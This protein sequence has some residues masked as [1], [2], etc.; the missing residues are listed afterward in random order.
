[1]LLATDKTVLT[2]HAG[3]MAQWPVYLTICNLSHEIQRSGIRPGGMMVGLI[4]IHKRDSLEV[5]IE[6]Y[7]QTMGVITKCKSKCHILRKVI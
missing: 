5:K 2:K 6:I 7:H 3:D 4:P 1:M